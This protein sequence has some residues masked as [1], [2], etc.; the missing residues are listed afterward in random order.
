VD[1][2]LDGSEDLMT[3]PTKDFLLLIR[4]DKINVPTAF[5]AYDEERKEQ[6]IIVNMLPDIKPEKM[7]AKFLNTV[8]QSTIDENPVFSYATLKD[9]RLP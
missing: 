8:P 5:S 1:V 3:A 6:A 4:D 7:R 2:T 9:Y